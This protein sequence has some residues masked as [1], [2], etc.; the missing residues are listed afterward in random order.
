MMLKPFVVLKKKAITLKKRRAPKDPDTT[1]IKKIRT[2]Q[3][4]ERPK[5]KKITNWSLSFA[6][7]TPTT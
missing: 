1:Y 2:V 7:R 5:R 6:K 4:T 3:L